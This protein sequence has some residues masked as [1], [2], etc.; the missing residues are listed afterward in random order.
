M[1]GALVTI[2]DGEPTATSLVIAEH[3]GN[4]HKNVL[5]LLHKHRNAIEAACGEVAFETRLN[6]QGS[7][8]EYAILTESQATAL[9]TLMQNSKRVVALK[10]MLAAEFLRM[11]QQLRG[12]E[13]NRRIDGAKRALLLT[14]TDAVTPRGLR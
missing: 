4:D 10:V 3:V 8:T 14:C 11:R 5:A 1:D 7:P 6:P 13:K 2:I 12:Q 9:L